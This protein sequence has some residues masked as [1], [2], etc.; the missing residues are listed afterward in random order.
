VDDLVGVLA[1]SL[2]AHQVRLQSASEAFEP[3]RIIAI[4]RELQQIGFLEADAGDRTK[5]TTLGAIVANSPLSVQSA[6]RVTRA[7]RPAMPAQL[8]RATLLTAA[9]VTTELDAL[10][11]TVNRKGIQKELGTFLGELQTR[12]AASVLNELSNSADRLAVASRAKKAVACLLWTNGL[13]LGDIEQAVMRHY[14]D[15][16]ASGPI[17]NVIACSHA[18]RHRHR[19]RYR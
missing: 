10:N 8:T 15:R 13:P 7:L 12:V 11:L 17:G 3:T 6:I 2:A 1:N 18:R 16:N 5:P 9:Q 14:Y 4:V 19:A